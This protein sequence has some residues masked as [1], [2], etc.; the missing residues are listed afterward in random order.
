[1]KDNL[2][3]GL[4]VLATTLI[5]AGLGFFFFIGGATGSFIGG[6]GGLL[7]GFFGSGIVLMVLGWIRA[8]K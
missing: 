2:Y 7:F 1:M 5:G 8:S 4:A 3:Q 6:F